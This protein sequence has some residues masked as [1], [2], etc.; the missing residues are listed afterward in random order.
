ML[1]ESFLHKV[2][3]DVLVVL[4]EAYFEYVENEDYFT[5]LDFLNDYQN[6]IVLRT[7]SKIH[8]LAGIRM[9]YGIASEEIIS[10][11]NR[12]RSPFNTSV[13]AQAAA[14]AALED[15]DH[16]E[17][18]KEH[19]RLQK[20]ILEDGFNDL[21]IPFIPSVS[22]FILLLIQDADQIYKELL[23]HGIIVRSMKSLHCN[24]GL[25][26]TVGKEEDNLAL[27]KSLKL[28]L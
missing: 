9:G 25:R 13:M 16:I 21:K 4:D 28:V 6:L 17:K 10:N 11:L 19:N 12:V 14:K 1:F 8:G 18:S 24:D 2:P 7:F 27:L 26:I 3:S 15:H 22:N 23:L 20:K 5:G